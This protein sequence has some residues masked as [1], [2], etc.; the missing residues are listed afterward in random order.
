VSGI[1]NKNTADPAGDISFV[2]SKKNLTQ[3]CLHYPTAPGC[4]TDVEGIDIYGQLVIE[5][6]GQWGPY[7][8]CNPADGWDTTDWICGQECIQPTHE[9]CPP[10]SH[11]EHNGSHHNALECWCD[12]TARTAGREAAP[13]SGHSAMGDAGYVPQC[14]SSFSPW[15]SKSGGT[16]CA[17][18]G[19]EGKI[20]A[21]L[22][23]W[24]FDSVSSMACQK[25]HADADCTGWVS[26][27]N[28]T[29]YLFS[30][31]AWPVD[32]PGCVGGKK[33]D[34]PWDKYG[35]SWF[36][37]ANLGDGYT[38]NL[39]Y[40]TPAEGECKNGAPLGTDGCTWRLVSELKYANATCVDKQADAAVERHG[41]ACFDR[42]PHPLDRNTDCY[43]D[44]YRNTLMGDASQ[45][46]TRI[47]PQD[48]IDPWV[49]A[50][51][52]DDP[53]Q[54]GCPHVQPSEGPFD[55]RKSPL[56]SRP[57]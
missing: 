46:I 47:P 11:G 54:G 21:N 5:V 45:N 1:L 33:Y 34:N 28:L 6:D 42:C 7:L 39:W 9:G 17:K 18:P 31:P 52:Y 43:L 27:D 32:T 4:H 16:G 37:V 38:T 49:A 23:G 24:S 14:A 36:G 57:F 26:L 29:A 41:R 15:Q 56:I 35:G 12:R 40:S 13:H 2:I 48:M 53:A 19:V 44:C 10:P 20:Y 50:F 22:S 30:G 51:T 8:M 55:A 3:T 25:C